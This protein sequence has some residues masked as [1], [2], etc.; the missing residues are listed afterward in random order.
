MR[1]INIRRIRKACLTTTTF[2][3]KF[4]RKEPFEEENQQQTDTAGN[5][6]GKRPR[7]VISRYF[8]EVSP[9]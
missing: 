3:V 4:H 8:I 5:E 6:Y 9:S 2:C 7:V 1:P